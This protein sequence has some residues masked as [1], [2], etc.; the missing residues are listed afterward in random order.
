MC[1]ISG[2]LNLKGSFFNEGRCRDILLQMTNC[3][4]HRGPDGQG[5]WLDAKAGIAL[6]HRRLSIVDVSPAGAQ[7]MH[8]HCGRYVLSYNGEIYNISELRGAVEAQRGRLEWRGHSDTEVFLEACATFGVEQAA[9]RTLGMFAFAL[10]DRLERVLTLGRDRFGVK[11]LYW[12]HQGMTFLFGSELKALRQHPAFERSIDRNALAAFFRCN[13]LPDPM[14]PF[15]KVYKLRP[16]HLLTVG[17]T[18]PVREMS[19]WSALEVALSG[20][21]NRIQS[22]KDALDELHELLRDAV[23]RRMVADVPVGAFLSGGIDSSLI[24]ALMQEV[25][26]HAVNTFSI[27]FENVDFDEAPY[28]K[29]IAQCLGTNHTEFYVSYKD[30]KAVIPRMPEMYDSLFADSSQIPTFLLSSLA[31]RS[32]AVSLSGDGG[33]EIFA[34]YPRHSAKFTLKQGLPL[35]RPLLYQRVNF[36]LWFGKPLVVGSEV[37]P[38]LYIHGLTDKMFKDNGE[39]IQYIDTVHYLPGDI[40][41]KVDRA[42]MATSLEVR[43]P[44]LDHRIYALAWRMAPNLRRACGKSKWPLRHILDRY[45]SPELTDRPKQGFS[46]PMVTW[47]RGPLREWAEDLLR[48]Q[49]LHREGWLNPDVVLP[50]WRNTLEGRESGEQIW[51]VLMFQAWLATQATA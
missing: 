49:R 18:V 16:G 42:S 5:I 33:D 36:K 22:H 3:L 51:G 8:S 50:V 25:S 17:A 14:T 31:R 43:T 32:V 13:Y 34:G 10:W 47:L 21:E 20:V 41:E 9:S 1:G 15:S 48:P 23:R 30:A 11:P 26:P 39:M 46:V 38:S 19:W 29:T 45:I 37:S 6:G 40:L 7:P 35:P 28:A 4:Q 44:F 2:F 27:G 12:T 24:S